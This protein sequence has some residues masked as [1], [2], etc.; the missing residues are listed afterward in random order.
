MSGLLLIRRNSIIMK[1]F[2]YYKNLIED[3]CAKLKEHA[4]EI[5]EFFDLKSYDNATESIHKNKSWS[6]VKSISESDFLLSLTYKNEKYSLS[7]IFETDE[8]VV[9]PL[10]D[11]SIQISFCAK[12]QLLNYMLSKQGKIDF[13]NKPFII[14]NDLKEELVEYFHEQYDEFNHVVIYDPKN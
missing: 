11:I 3:D 8:V 1:T 4:F 2:N 6:V 7:Y 10:D 5:I 12:K 14:A 13:K 9:F